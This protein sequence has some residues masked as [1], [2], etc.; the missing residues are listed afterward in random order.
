MIKPAHRPSLRG[1]ILDNARSLARDGETISLDTAARASGL[2]KP[3]LMYHFPTKVALMAALVDHVMDDCERELT[4]RLQAHPRHDTG[5]D[6]RHDTGGAPVRE[7]LGAYLD[8][9]CDGDFDTSDLV[10]FIDPRLREPM[11]ER[12]AERIEPWLQVPDDLPDDERAR[13]LGVR[14]IADGLWFAA[15]S[16]GVV[17]TSDERDGV[18]ALARRMLGEEA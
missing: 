10:M 8:W 12:W 9:V 14:L 2:T 15:A 18:R 4:A 3:G 11:T 16:G 5:H 13:L 6:T 7:R 1:D 17:P